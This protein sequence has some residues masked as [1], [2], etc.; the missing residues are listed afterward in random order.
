MDGQCKG[1]VAPEGWSVGESPYL[2]PPL[3]SSSEAIP[4]IRM[5]ALQED[6]YLKNWTFLGTNLGSW[7]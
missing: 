6:F 2:L 7:T 3:P 4:C 1:R 5:H